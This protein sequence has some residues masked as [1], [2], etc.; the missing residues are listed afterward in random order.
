MSCRARLPSANNSNHPARRAD[1][2]L[3]RNSQLHAIALMLED[4]R[5]EPSL[6]WMNREVTSRHAGELDVSSY[7]I[8]ARGEYSGAAH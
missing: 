4:V 2:S 1:I 8:N 5:K 3:E 6:E 7:R